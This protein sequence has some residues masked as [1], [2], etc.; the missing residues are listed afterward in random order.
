MLSQSSRQEILRKISARVGYPVG[1]ERLTP[2]TRQAITNLATV[3]RHLFVVTEIL[4]GENS[5]I[6]RS[7]VLRF[8][9]RVG[10][11]S[12][13]AER[14]ALTG[15]I[16]KLQDEIDSKVSD[17]SNQVIAEDNARMSGT[18]PP[19]YKGALE[20]VE[21]KCPSCGA[22]LPLPTSRFITCQYC[23]GTFTIQDV[24]SQL[25]SMIQG[26]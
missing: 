24:S 8:A 13:K 6:E 16:S 19:E 10:R 22:G 21:L 9:S 15:E 11:D 12:E 1:E 7:A 2:S 5:R 4:R 26:I 20:L 18:P 25:R 23:K 3:Q 17:L 14:A